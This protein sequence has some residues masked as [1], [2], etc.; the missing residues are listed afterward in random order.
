MPI[1][2]PKYKTSHDGITESGPLIAD[3]HGVYV[4]VVDRVERKGLF[5]KLTHYR[6]GYVVVRWEDATGYEI[7]APEQHQFAGSTINAA[8][9][10]LTLKTA[11]NQHSFTLHRTSVT[12][13]RNE[14]GPYL[15]M[16]DARSA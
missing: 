4:G 15:A 5:K 1:L 12:T 10:I 16:I 3:D 6:P 14:L 13:V 11:T 9:V 2:T 7:A 8:D